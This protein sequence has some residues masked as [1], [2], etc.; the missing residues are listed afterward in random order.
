MIPSFEKLMEEYKALCDEGLIKSY[1]V[2]AVKKY[3]KEYLQARV[4]D[5]RINHYTISEESDGISDHPQLLVYCFSDK[6]FEFSPTFE[7]GLNV[8][9]WDFGRKIE[10]DSSPKNKPYGK[11]TYFYFINPI[12]PIDYKKLDDFTAKVV[13]ENHGIFYHV[14][15][16]K[17]KEKIEK[18]GLIPHKSERPDFQ[19]SDERL[20]ITTSWENAIEFYNLQTKTDEREYELKLKNVNFIGNLKKQGKFKFA[21]QD[22]Q[23]KNLSRVAIF[24]ILFESMIRDFYN[25]SRNKNKSFP[26]KIYHDYE[27]GKK[28]IAYFI[29]ESIPAKYVKFF[30]EYP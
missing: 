8:Y 21:P 22:K 26:I 5:G 27:Y 12:F 19:H 20:Y 6:P 2:D 3:I 18:K 1:E 13:K 7:N 4:K 30:I 9:G 14:A 16:F 28:N 29:K 11:I 15:P 23:T 10:R 24:A 25:N 17:L